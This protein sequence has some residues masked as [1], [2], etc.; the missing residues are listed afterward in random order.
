MTRITNMRHLLPGILITALIASGCGSTK[1]T[2]TTRNVSTVP[3]EFN[4]VNM[5]NLNSGDDDFAPA[6]ISVTDNFVFTSNRASTVRTERI[7]NKIRYGEAIYQAT[8]IP[9]N[10]AGSGMLFPKFSDAFSHGGVTEAPDGKTMYLGA[11]YT[12]NG[13]GGG[14]IFRV[15]RT[16]GDW[17]TPTPVPRL[18]TTW[19]EGHP[20]LSPDGN[21][22]VFASNRGDGEPTV[23]TRGYRPPKLYI[24]TRDYS[25]VWQEPQRMPAPVNSEFSEIS[26]FFASNGF[27]YFATNRYDGQGFDIVRTKRMADGWTEPERMPAPVNSSASDV[28]PFI[29]KDGATIYFASDRSGGKGGLDIYR[30]DFPAQVKLRGLVELVAPEEPR[31]PAVNVEVLITELGT[32]N[33]WIVRTNTAGEYATELST[34]KNYE[35]K[36]GTADCFNPGPPQQVIV[37]FPDNLDTTFV[38]D[39]EIRRVVFPTFQLGQY[40]IPFFVTGYYY[41]NTNENLDKLNQRVQSGEL[42]SSSTPYIDRHDE[43]YRDYATRIEQIFDEVYTEIINGILPQFTDCALATEDLVVEVRGYVDPRGLSPGIYVDNTVTTEKMTIKKGESMAGQTG[44]MKLANLRAYYTLQMIDFEL[45]KRSPKYL[46]LKQQNRVKLH[47]Y[48]V[49]IDTETPGDK[50]QDPAKRRIDIKLSIGTPD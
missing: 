39:F 49:G 28:F 24:S 7:D 29:T 2:Q 40:N 27:L 33:S 18:N 16:A 32:N 10:Y 4:V 8:G 3:G 21:T 43:P 45:M 31:K 20:A 44:N 50:Q 37:G 30:S 17:S 25:G 1:Q 46:E 23:E 48:G 34:N 12:D 35:V 5:Q 9:P 47:A 36:T 38:R 19:W 11:S 14:D 22:I 13:V 26:P 15:D 6:V 41:P 42:S